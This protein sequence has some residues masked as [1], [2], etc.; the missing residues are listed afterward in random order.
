MSDEFARVL[1][2]LMANRSLTRR[3]M[4]RAAH[5][6]ESTINQLMTG[7]LPPTAE[8]LQDI[9]PAM[10]MSVD[11]LLVIAGLNAEYDPNRPGLYAA[12][13]E[14]GSLVAAASHLPV[15]QIERLTQIARQLQT[16]QDDSGAVGDAGRGI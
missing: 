4:S 7:A 2:G 13:R 16:R 8:L 3:T 6:A 14:V 5:R 9:A 12:S 15:E 1:R 11:D 10:Q